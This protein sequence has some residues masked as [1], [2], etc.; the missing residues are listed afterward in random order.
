MTYR[1]EFEKL[2][3]RML[4]GAA[5][6]VYNPAFWAARLLVKGGRV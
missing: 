5:A 4:D 1:L 3:S 6:A 2:A